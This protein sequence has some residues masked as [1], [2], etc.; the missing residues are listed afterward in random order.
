[1]LT[2]RHFLVMAGRRCGHRRPVPNAERRHEHAD[3]DQDREERA[4][5]H[6]RHMD[7]NSLTGNAAPTNGPVDKANDC[8]DA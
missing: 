2:H 5:A 8:P 3:G 6:G 1:M 4:R 7:A